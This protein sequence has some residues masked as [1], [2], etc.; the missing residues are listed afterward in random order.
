MARRKSLYD[1]SWWYNLSEEEQLEYLVDQ[2]AKYEQEKAKRIAE[3]SIPFELKIY[4]TFTK[5]IIEPLKDHHA[6]WHHYNKKVNEQIYYNWYNS[7]EEALAK[8]E[9]KMEQYVNPTLN[10]KY[11]DCWPIHN[12]TIKLMKGTYVVKSQEF[13]I[14]A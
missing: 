12:V 11:Y 4:A 13:K 6:R 2:H 3:E 8:F 5:E 10:S 9:E 1:R 14:D 7:K